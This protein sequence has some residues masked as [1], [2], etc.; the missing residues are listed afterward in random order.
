MGFQWTYI[1]QPSWQKLWREDEMTNDKPK[2]KMTRA[3]AIEAFQKHTLWHSDNAIGLVDFY[4]EAGM[5]EIVK[6]RQPET[7][8]CI[9]EAFGVNDVIRLQE[10]LSIN[11]YKI[12]KA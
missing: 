8:K 11:G 2:V 3:E 6:E 12:T 4:I 1:E 9:F 5:L 10:V 7:L